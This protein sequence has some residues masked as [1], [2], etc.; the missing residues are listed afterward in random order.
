M[1]RS[2]VPRAG[3]SR[4]QFLRR[5]CGE[6]VPVFREI[7]DAFDPQNQLNP[8]K[9]IGDDPH[10]LLRDLKVYPRLVAAEVAGPDP[11]SSWLRAKGEPGGPSEPP[12]DLL[13]PSDV[14]S[15]KLAESTLPAAVNIHPALRWPELSLVDT[16]LAC[17]ACGTC[18]SLDPALRMCPS[19]RG[20]RREAA[21]P[22]AQANLVRQLLAGEIDPRLWGAEEFK[23]N[24]D[25]CIH[26]KQCTSECPSGVDVSSLMLEAKA[27]YVE[28][29]GL[30][31]RDW[32]SSRVELWAR[33]G[34]QFPP[35]SNF[36]MS[37]RRVRWLVE[38]LLGLSRHRV[39]PPVRAVSFTRRAARLGLNKPRPQ[40]TGP[41]VVYFVQR[42]RQLLRP[43]A[44]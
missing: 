44:G 30:P 41:R 4:T 39:L 12:D 18:R 8:G 43:G 26:C 5:Q 13:E 10:L 6:L 1:A 3:A 20:S 25:L 2:R 7:K 19:F 35:L 21:S 22:R 28:K 16:A 29:H 42:V 40:Q 31:T 37:R 27:A 17:N 9:V 33:L 32:I 36:L 24:A 38:R 23:A 11:P 14:G 15:A 34:S